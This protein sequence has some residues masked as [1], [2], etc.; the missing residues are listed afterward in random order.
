[1]MMSMS[2]PDG[3]APAPGSGRSAERAL[4]A[5]VF[6][7]SVVAALGVL[8]VF[9]SA[10]AVYAVRNVLV[11][12]VIAMFIAVSLDPAVRWLQTRHLTR[13]WAVTLVL[14][15]V[16]L[17]VAGFIAAVV[18]P[19][20]SQ[21]DQLTQNVPAYI[22]MLRDRSETLRDLGDQ[23]GMT[24]KITTL[25]ESVPE[26]VG[27]TALG[28]VQR[29]FGALATGLL[30]LVLT[31]Y[32]MI[33]LP[34]IRRGF[35]RL[36]Y[37]DHQPGVAAASDVVVDKVGQYMIGN[38]A[39][40][41]A[42]GVGT[43]IVL[44]ALG[45]PYALPLAVLVALTDIIPLIGATIGAVVVTVIAAA[46]TGL[47]PAGALVAIFF[48]LYQQV[49][50]YF[51]APRI[52]RNAVNL[53]TVAVLLA[54]LIGA[55]MLGLVGALMA[56]PLAAAGKEV[57]AQVRQGRQ[58]KQLAEDYAGPPVGDLRQSDTSA[59][60]GSGTASDS[61]RPSHVTQPAAPGQHAAGSEPAD[62]ADG[63]AP[64]GPAS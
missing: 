16:L 3:K 6:R 30:V 53:S 14:L 27:T 25:L 42:A 59:A 45:V 11:L 8:A 41:L 44:L 46:S 38:L 56:I 33:D 37:R 2:G 43:F 26:R 48:L 55:T 18:P 5:R 51:L 32:F 12:A 10:W 34:R 21:A 39:I 54:G 40:S 28:F 4:Q 13:G 49:E 29:F 61:T 62:P 1:M 36:F 9:L 23:Y 50:N 20:V 60:G 63:L 15:V 64:A 57:I 22:D 47:W 35:I 24:G 19:I 31:I 7:L 58:A 17:L 52:M